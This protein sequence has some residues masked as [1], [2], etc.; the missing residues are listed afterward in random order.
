L[1]TSRAEEQACWNENRLVYQA[2][3]PG[4]AREIADSA[5]ESA[6]LLLRD[7]VPSDKTDVGRRDRQLLALDYRVELA[8]D[9][10]RCER[11]NAGEAE[12]RLALTRAWAI[13]V[14]AGSDR[15]IDRRIS[16]RKQTYLELRPEPF[17]GGYCKTVLD[18]AAKLTDAAWHSPSISDAGQP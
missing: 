12:R 13:S 8:V 16:K 7:R 11:T 1:P 4:E 3:P 10:A 2:V 6:R 17:P 15:E 9:I 5:G 18:Y 14:G